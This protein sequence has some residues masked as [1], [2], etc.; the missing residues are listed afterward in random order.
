MTSAALLNTAVRTVYFRI[1]LACKVLG[2]YFAS[3]SL[4]CKIL[5]LKPSG[6]I[7]SSRHK[8]TEKQSFDEVILKVNFVRCVKFVKL[9][10]RSLWSI[11][12]ENYLELQN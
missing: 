1:T 6:A 4:N 10:S 7:Y 3:C 2:K 5:Q 8:G 12:C 11:F 9:V